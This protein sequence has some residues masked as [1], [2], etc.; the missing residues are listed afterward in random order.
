METNPASYGYLRVLDL[1][2]GRITP[3]GGL[4]FPPKINPQLDWSHDGAD[5]ILGMDNGKQGR[6]A[7]WHRQSHVVTVL[8]AAVPNSNYYGFGYLQLAGN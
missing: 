1:R 2:T 6:V 7:F 3:I 4:R 5:L 8:A